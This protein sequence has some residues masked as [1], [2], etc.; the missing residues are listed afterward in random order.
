MPERHGKWKSVYDRFNHWR[1]DGTINRILQRLQV[2]LD[3]DGR[4]DWDL[5]CIDGTN[6]RASRSAAGAASSTGSVT[7]REFRWPSR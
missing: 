3:H 7:V 4:I 2:R 5:W 6:V 1:K